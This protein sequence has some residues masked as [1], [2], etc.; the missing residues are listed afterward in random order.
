MDKW[1]THSWCLHRCSNNY[2]LPNSQT[3]EACYVINHLPVKRLSTWHSKHCIRKANPGEP[4]GLPTVTKRIEPSSESW[5]SSA[6]AEFDRQFQGAHEIENFVKFSTNSCICQ[7][8]GSNIILPNGIR[9]E[10]TA[11]WGYT[12]NGDRGGWR[13]LGRNVLTS[14]PP[15]REGQGPLWVYLQK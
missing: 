2:S 7:A 11:R 14:H 10:I 9:M 6:A 13:F 4:L 8:S 3:T 15:E 12:E 1:T 5:M